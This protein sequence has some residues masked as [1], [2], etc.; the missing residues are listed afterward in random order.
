MNYYISKHKNRYAVFSVQDGV[1]KTFW[2][3]WGATRF[4]NK[5]RRDRRLVN[6]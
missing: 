5:L 1:L 3:L 4:I 6:G 2:T